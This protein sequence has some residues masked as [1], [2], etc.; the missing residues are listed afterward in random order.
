VYYNDGTTS[1]FTTPPGPTYLDPYPSP[2]TGTAPCH[3]EDIHLFKYSA[4]FSV[5][6][7]TVDDDD[8]RDGVSGKSNVATYSVA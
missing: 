6:L 1:L 7:Y 3:Y 4:G 2:W 8:G 5:S